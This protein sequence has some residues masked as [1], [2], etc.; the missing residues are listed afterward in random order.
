MRACDASR[1]GDLTSPHL[2][3]HQTLACPHEVHQTVSNAVCPCGHRPQC[4]ARGPRTQAETRVSAFRAYLT[5]PHLSAPNARLPARGPPDGVKCRLP[6]R[7]SSSM[8]R[9][10]PADPGRNQSVCLPACLPA[11]AFR[12][13]KP[14][15][16]PFGRLCLPAAFRPATHAP[17]I[18]V[19]LSTRITSTPPAA[20]LLPNRSRNRIAVPLLAGHNPFRRNSSLRT[21]YSR[22]QVDPEFP[23]VALALF[24][25]CQLAHNRARPFRNRQ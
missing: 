10:R 14:E 17:T 22:E 21:S 3:A 9:S 8:L 11:S 19:A 13:Q 4:C 24:C 7:P 1:P 18:G 20:G 6:V 23:S 2:S 12:P 15:C 5:S 16:L 25:K